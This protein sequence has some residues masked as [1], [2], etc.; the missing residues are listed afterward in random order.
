MNNYFS[1]SS[2]WRDCGQYYTYLK[3]MRREKKLTQIDKENEFRCKLAL[4]SLN[5]I[6]LPLRKSIMPNQ[7]IQLRNL[8][9]LLEDIHRQFQLLAEKNSLVMS[10]RVPTLES[11]KLL[12]EIR[13]TQQTIL[14][15]CQ[16]R[17]CYPAD[18]N[19]SAYRGFLWLAFL[20][21]PDYFMQHLQFL[22]NFLVEWNRQTSHP[23]D[24]RVCN[25]TF[26]FQCK[27]QKDHYHV[28]ISEG[29]LFCNASSI[30]L[31]VT[32]CLQTKRKDLAK[33]RA[34]SRSTEYKQVMAMLWQH[35][36]QS[37]YSTNGNYY[38]LKTLFYKLNAEYFHNKLE[39]PQLRWSNRKTKRRLGYFHPET[40]TITLSRS[41]DQKQVPTYVVEYVLYHEMLH[42][43]LG[44]KSRNSYRIAHTSQ[45]KQEERK[46]KFYEEAENFLKHLPLG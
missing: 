43:K 1:S 23:I 37:A 7:R 20:S 31:L 38:D 17:G 35:T 26:I 36:A 4:Q 14:Q 33:L 18:L 28:T 9:P 24:I 44:L 29:F 8:T 16:K 42:K 39:Q 5:I 27:T 11:K 15:N 22:T 19:D 41:L 30:H 21:K 34:L 3:K 46:Y 25:C 13:S 2:Y 6:I 12:E 40:D 10:K 45:F 32:C